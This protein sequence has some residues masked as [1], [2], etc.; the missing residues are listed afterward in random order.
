MA[1]PI[2]YPHFDLD[3][4]DAR[5]LRMLC[6]LGET[7]SF[8]ETARRMSLTQSAIS[9]SLK[10]LESTLSLLLVERSG[11]RAILTQNGQAL[12]VRADRILR[13]MARARI[14]MQQLAEW[15]S[16]SLRL[17]ATATACQYFLP[18]VLR[19]FRQSYPKWQIAVS[20]GDTAD[21]IESL[22]EGV[23]D[24]AICTD[25]PTIEGHLE[26]R[27]LFDEELKLILPI[28]HRFAD[29]K[30]LPPADAIQ[31][32]WITYKTSSS[33]TKRAKE[34]FEKA[35]VRAP[36]ASIELGSMEAVK[37]M[38]KLGLGIALVPHWSVKKEIKEGTL[39]ATTLKGPVLRR[40]WSLA[41]RA[42]R[43]LNH[44]EEELYRLCKTAAPAS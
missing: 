37:E 41:H 30:N 32:P 36:R 27:P 10:S 34:W 2:K 13:E 44:G 22:M 12:V 3:P 14:E 9:H 11:R 18:G 39:A 24:I 16:S 20:S 4:F 17:A 6:L 25:S 33:L 1:Q 28:G 7:G 21:I 23:H 8:T 29:T 40:R 5:Q 43:R 19:E 38:V 42:G 15:G 26:F 35:G 31:E